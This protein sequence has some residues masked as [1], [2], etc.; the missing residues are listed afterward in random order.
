ML[1]TATTNYS[2]QQEFRKPLELGHRDEE[3]IDYDNYD[4]GEGDIRE[5]TGQGGQCGLLSIPQSCS[6]PPLATIGR[7]TAGSRLGRGEQCGLLATTQSCSVSSPAT[8][9]GRLT[10]AAK[11]Y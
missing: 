3:H 5:Q 6:A 7:G 2:N 1:N 8:L 11:R 9:V 4:R 10:L